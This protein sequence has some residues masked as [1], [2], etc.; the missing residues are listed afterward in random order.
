M[1][2]SEKADAA[3]AKL[4]Q[5]LPAFR[6]WTNQPLERQWHKMLSHMD[7]QTLMSLTVHALR[8]ITLNRDDAAQ[9]SLPR[10]LGVNEA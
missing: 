7:Q 10:D 1:T 4:L 2:H 8:Q 5:C 9:Q 6:R 3:I